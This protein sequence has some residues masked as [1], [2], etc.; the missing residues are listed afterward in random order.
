[1][2][3]LAPAEIA[4]SPSRPSADLFCDAV[5]QGAAVAALSAAARRPVHAYLF[6]GPAGTGA[7]TLARAFAAALLCP[8]GGCA[9][10]STCR[11]ALAGTHPDLV[12]IERSGPALRASEAREVV[13]AAHR[14]PLEAA[15]QVIV[16][17]DVHLATAIVPAL[18]KTVEE[19]PPATVMVLT[20]ETVPSE[21]VPLASRCAR[22][23]LRAVPDEIVAQW[24][25]ASGVGSAAAADAASAARGSPERARVLADDPELVARQARWRSVPDHLDG[26]GAS[27]AGLAAELVDGIDKAVAVLAQRQAG[28][29][30]ALAAAAEAMG[31]R[32]GPARRAL[33]ERHKREQRRWRTEEWRMGL[34]VLAGAY[35][36]RVVAAGSG[37]AGSE[38]GSGPAGSGPGT[39]LAVR[40]AVAAMHL[41]EDATAALVRN[42]NERLLAEALLLHLAR[43]S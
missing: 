15:R 12:E 1:M 34:A 27:A 3:D 14:R 37:P 24:L 29:A 36:D 13:T 6:V 2:S 26:T 11:R 7:G 9:S 16:V 18:L 33:E 43:L 25:V 31:E 21:L 5:G 23:A 32:S 22:V 17:P 20:A 41:V 4:A 38:P 8:A 39:R 35:R 42:P 10:C 30:E 40:Q 28:Q 19:P